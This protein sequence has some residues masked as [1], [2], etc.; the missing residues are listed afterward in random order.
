M[1]T[2]NPLL[3][4][5]KP[6][7]LDDLDVEKFTWQTPK[8]EEIR[9][10]ALNKLKWHPHEVKN[11]ISIVEQ[12]RPKGWV[13]SNQAQISDYFKKQH[14]FAYFKSKRIGDAIKKIKNKG[15]PKNKFGS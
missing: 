13:F 15:K 11:T 7:S 12:K 14:N 4:S 3:V 5:H 8:Y 10:I 1:D 9:R 6:D 2:K